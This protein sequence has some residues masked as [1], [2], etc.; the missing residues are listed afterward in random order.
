MSPRDQGE[1]CTP[2][3]QNAFLCPVQ[4]LAPLGKQ[5]GETEQ[6]AVCATSRPATSIHVQLTSGYYFFLSVIPH[7]LRSLP[8]HE[9]LTSLGFSHISVRNTTAFSPC[10]GRQAR[11]IFVVCRSETRSTAV[12][13]CRK[14]RLLT[15]N[16]FLAPF[17]AFA[18]KI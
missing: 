16:Q 5:Y 13:C 12:V 11:L 18:S 4:I 7:S 2:G 15:A 1:T 17:P 9:G 14:C 6:L 10:A 8:L 3:T